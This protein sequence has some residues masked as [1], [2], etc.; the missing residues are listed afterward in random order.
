MTTMTDHQRPEGVPP[1][2]PYRPT[3][4]K[5]A[6][7]EFSPPIAWPFSPS[8]AISRKVG[9]VGEAGGAQ[10]V[11]PIRAPYQASPSRVG[12]AFEG[13]PVDRRGFDPG[14]AWDDHGTALLT[15]PAHLGGRSVWAGR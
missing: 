3:S 4:R 10:A 12:R 5:P 9:K 1:Y 6:V 2:L 14:R 8:S 13:A 15:T 11:E 7:L